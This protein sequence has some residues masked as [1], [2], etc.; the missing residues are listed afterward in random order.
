MEDFNFFGE[1]QKYFEPELERKLEL[2]NSVKKEIRS[3]M[4]LDYQLA[5]SN[6]MLTCD[7]EQFY[8][9]QI[10]NAYKFYLT[11]KNFQDFCDTFKY[12]FNKD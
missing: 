4:L 3:I 12:K 5:I 6:G 7:F 9:E 2:E 8:N 1:K 11:C 10:D